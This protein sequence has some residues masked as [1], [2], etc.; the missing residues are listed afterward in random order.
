MTEM[1]GDVC[2]CN[3]N[4]IKMGGGG[5]KSTEGQTALIG[6]QGQPRHIPC[7]RKKE[8]ERNLRGVSREV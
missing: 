8:F 6:V 3:V 7:K 1:N 5:A 2:I 4:E